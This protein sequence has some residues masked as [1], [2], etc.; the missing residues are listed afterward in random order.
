MICA[1]VVRAAQL[2]FEAELSPA[3]PVFVRAEAIDLGV[4]LEA[5]GVAPLRSGAV[6]LDIEAVTVASGH[7][8]AFLVGVGTCGGTELLLEQFLLADVA[9]ERAMLEAVAARA[10]RAPLLTYNGRGFDM[11][12]LASRCVANGLHPAVIEPRSHDDLLAATRRHFRHRLRSCTLAEVEAAVLGVFREDD[13]SGHEGPGRYCVWLR[14]APAHVMS[15]VVSHNRMDVVSTA[16]LGAHLAALG[17]PLPA[18]PPLH[19][20]WCLTAERA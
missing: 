18:L 16:L 14:G 9:G 5:L 20:A 13:V 4:W 2:G 17:E 3:G 10:R 15:G 19:A 11:R 1:S 7:L 8:A 12:V 6:A